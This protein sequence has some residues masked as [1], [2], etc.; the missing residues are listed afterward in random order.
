MSINNHMIDGSDEY[1]TAFVDSGTTFTYFPS[2]LYDSMLY[3]MD[4]F[5]KVDP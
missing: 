4:W 1:K 2:A 3:H 5:C